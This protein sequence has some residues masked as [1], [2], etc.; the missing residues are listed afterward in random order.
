LRGVPHRH[1]IL[2]PHTF[3]SD[4]TRDSM[5][6]SALPAQGRDPSRRRP[7]A[8]VLAIGFAA[9]FL[10]VGYEF[11]RSASSSL[12]ITTYG[13]DRLPRVMAVGPIGTF[14]LLY[15]YVRLLSRLGS[16]LTLLFT[17]LLTS[18]VLAGCFAAIAS[19]AHLPVAFLYVFREAYIVLMVEQY[20]SFINSTLDEQQ[21]RRWNGPVCGIGSIGGILGGRLVSQYVGSL[22]TETFILLAAASILPAAICCTIAYRL[23]PGQPLDVE[24]EG[25][26]DGGGRHL[27]LSLFRTHP[28]LV[29]LGSL[30]VVTQLM[31]TVLDLRFHWLLEEAMPGPELGDVRT[32]YMGEFWSNVN[33][34][35]FLLQF[36]LVPLLLRVLPLRAVHGGIP[37]IHIAAAAA[38]ILYPSLGV[39]AIAFLI[40][41]SVDYSLFRA[42]KEILYIPLPFDARYRVKEFNDAFMYRASKGGA[43]GLVA[44]A[45]SHFGRLPGASM[46]ITALLSALIWLA[47]VFGLL[48]EDH[49]QS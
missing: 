28:R 43:S 4:S 12:F 45:T 31:S 46:A 17:S 3:S 7:I 13:A 48:K 20:W 15:G 33:S 38:L 1:E 32:A 27:A 6:R 2:L 34:A 5:T 26:T 39:G 9:L 21:A 36:A 47:L 25:S 29:L 40:F 8:A 19:G 44:L 30:T 22:G 42:A 14:L 37:I 24:E 10:F 41:K 23:A 49:D 16:N 11:I 18:A 35:S